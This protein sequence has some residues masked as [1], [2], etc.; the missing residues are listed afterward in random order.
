[1]ISS[2]AAERGRYVSMGFMYC[3]F[4][5][6][7]DSDRQLLSKRRCPPGQSGSLMQTAAFL[8]RETHQGEMGLCSDQQSAHQTAGVSGK[9]DRGR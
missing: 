2:E 3:R 5:R 9:S 6:G 1:M 4:C 8:N 7:K